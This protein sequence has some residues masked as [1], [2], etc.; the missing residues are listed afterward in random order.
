[1]TAER[2]AA[3]VLANTAGIVVGFFAFFVPA[4]IG[5]REAV[6]TIVL[7]AFTPLREALLAAIAYRAWIVLFDGINAVFVLIREARGTM[8]G[9]TADDGQAEQ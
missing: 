2:I 9:R 4:G 1:M 6:A 3:L 5:V 8:I 7:G